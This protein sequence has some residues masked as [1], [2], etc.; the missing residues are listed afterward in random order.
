MYTPI[1]D[2]KGFNCMPTCMFCLFSTLLTTNRRLVRT[3]FNFHPPNQLSRLLKP[4]KPFNNIFTDFNLGDL[5][6][7]VQGSWYEWSSVTLIQPIGYAL[8]C[9]L[10]TVY[11][12]VYCTLHFVSLCLSSST[13]LCSL[14]PLHSVFQDFLWRVLHLAN[15][16]Y[17]NQLCIIFGYL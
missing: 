4:S 14:C 9:V 6:N 12:K 13:V 8:L 1:V 7:V 10:C 16:A 11:F 5:P 17:I 3:K 2:T 15:C